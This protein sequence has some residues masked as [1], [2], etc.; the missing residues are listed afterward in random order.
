MKNKFSVLALC[1]SF[2]TFPLCSCGQTGS[3]ESEQSIFSS[4]IKEEGTFDIETV[5]K[6]ININGHHFEVPMKLS[7]LEDGLTYEFIDEK[8]EDNLY[9]VEIRD[10]NGVFLSTIADNANKKN[11]NAFLYNITVKDSNSH[12]S[13]LVPT[14]TTKEEV[15][16]KYGEPDYKESYLSK[17]YYTYG[18]KEPNKN[19]F[20]Y[21]EKKQ[22]IVV[23]IDENEIVEKVSITYVK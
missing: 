5:R 1:L 20:D 3:T 4:E 2:L 16:N 10:E 11:G 15:I 9:Q 19:D 8:I 18:Y 13:S 22:S 12:I 21:R 14:V 23:T 17:E 6:D 7:E